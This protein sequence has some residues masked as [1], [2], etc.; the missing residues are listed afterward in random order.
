MGLSDAQEYKLKLNRLDEKSSSQNA[1]NVPFGSATPSPEKVRRESKDKIE[2]KKTIVSIP[3]S[4]P[5][6]AKEEVEWD[7]NIDDLLPE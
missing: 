2:T 6:V 4:V 5:K 3:K 1:N 7:D